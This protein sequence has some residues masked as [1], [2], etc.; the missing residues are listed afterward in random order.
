MRR[1][2]FLEGLLI[3]LTKNVGN[4]ILEARLVKKINV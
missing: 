4:V 1:P 3:C 2:S